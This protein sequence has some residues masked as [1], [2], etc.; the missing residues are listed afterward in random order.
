MVTWGQGDPRHPGKHHASH[1]VGLEPKTLRLMGRE[2]CLQRPRG[3]VCEGLTLS[4]QAGQKASFYTPEPPWEGKM[5]HINPSGQPS[6]WGK[7]QGSGPSPSFSIHTPAQE[8]CSSSR[9]L[10]PLRCGRFSP[11][12]QLSPVLADSPSG[13]QP[14]LS[15]TSLP[16]KA[17][18][19]APSSLP[20]YYFNSG[21]KI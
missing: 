7:P 17:S 11:V 2:P 12:P 1:P 3:S 20:I 19:F 10:K 16:K 8:T 21:R 4:P 9:P 18:W 14:G 15:I 5:L 6:P 13:R